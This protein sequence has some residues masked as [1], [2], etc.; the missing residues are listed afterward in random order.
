MDISFVVLHYN[1]NNS[2]MH[3]VNSLIPYLSNNKFNV[4]IVIVDNGSP[5]EKFAS[6]YDKFPRKEHIH[7]IDLNTNLGFSKGNNVGYKYSKYQLHSDV[8]V[9]A[10]SDVY[11]PQKD[12]LDC[13]DKYIFKRHVDI[14]GPKIFSKEKNVNENPISRQFYTRKDVY[15]RIAKD[16]I[17]LISSHFWGFDNFLSRHFSRRSSEDDE[18][19][20]E[21]SKM[22]FHN[23]QLHGSC[24]IFANRYIGEE[25]GLYDKTF[26]YGEENILKYLAEL[27]HYKMSYIPEIYVCHDDGGS[28]P[29]TY[30]TSIKKRQFR[31]KNAIKSNLLLI[32]L[33]KGNSH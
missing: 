3:C 20:V 17:L 30:K 11:F 5:S 16:Y 26:M 29:G 23:F 28:T 9:L 13:V 7:L 21:K 25:D 18:T 31:Y 27:N 15:K 22:N 2:T 1:N 8:I 6:I 4:E 12:F 24:L 32:E 19:K 33:I 10:N 14:A